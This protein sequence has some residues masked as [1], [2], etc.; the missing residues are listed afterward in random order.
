MRTWPEAPLA[1]GRRAEGAA[2]PELRKTALMDEP[3]TG[4]GARAA[5]STPGG[6]RAPRVTDAP[7]SHVGSGP[8]RPGSPG[9][10]ARSRSGAE[11]SERAKPPA[12]SPRADQNPG[13]EA[14]SAV[15]DTPAAEQ[16]RLFLAALERKRSRSGAGDQPHDPG[17]TVI[18]PSNTKRPRTFRRRAGG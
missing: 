4:T 10:S 7:G 18:P 1:P 13:A 11:R 12:A 15:A 3:R 5:A 9:G 6:S 16:R 8:S 17:H 14:A 2:E